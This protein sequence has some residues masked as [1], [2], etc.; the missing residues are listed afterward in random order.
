[1]PDT[2]SVAVLGTGTIGAPMARNLARAGLDVRAWNRSREKAEPLAANGVAVAGTPADAVR[3]A[4]A[5][6]TM[7]HDAPA[8]LEVMERAAAGLAPGTVWIQSSTAGLDGLAEL[9]AFARERELVL[10]D[11]PVSGTRQP[12]E[13]GTL[14]VLA[15]GPPEVRE[16]IAPVFEAIGS[17]TRWVGEDAASGAATRLKLVVNSWVL[18][19]THGVAEA[20]ALAEG[21]GTD[22]EDF[23]AVVEGGPLDM[24]YL[25]AK[26]QLLLG[27][28][29]TPPSFAT[30]TAAKDTELIVAAGERAGVRLDM[31]AAGLERFRRAVGQGHGGEDMA[32]SYFASFDGT[33]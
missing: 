32:A 4:D 16:R 11:A 33:D 15:A 23:L 17:R 5:V 3:G 12:A 14:V 27:G 29:L 20:L 8:A 24:G 22:P 6:L 18:T 1:M 2:F 31:A 10:V 7:L 19:V 30:A 13:Q 21:L 9:A 28:S 26:S 25:K